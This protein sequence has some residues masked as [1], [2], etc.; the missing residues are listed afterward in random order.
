M[1]TKRTYNPKTLFLISILS[2][3]ALSCS[4]DPIL[5][6]M[7]NTSEKDIVVEL[8]GKNPFTLKKLQYHAQM[9][10]PGKRKVKFNYG[11]EMLFNLDYKSNIVLNPGRGNF[12]LKAI[13][14]ASSNQNELKG[15]NNHP[16]TLLVGGYRVIG[17]YKSLGNDII[18]KGNWS[19]GLRKTVPNSIEIKSEKY[20]LGY[21]SSTELKLMSEENLINEIELDYKKAIRELKESEAT[22]E[23]IKTIFE[24]TDAQYQHLIANLMQ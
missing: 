15:N 12:Y 6:E 2:I 8:D 19:F 17:D 21:A 5:L 3:L 24:L 7:Y 9:L 10:P 18:L 20:S 16:D 11:E 13:N 23:M 4:K 22:D 1:I 14:Y